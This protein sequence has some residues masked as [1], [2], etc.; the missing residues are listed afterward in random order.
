MRV[1]A[2]VVADRIDYV[3]QSKRTSDS[4]RIT[5][6]C[7]TQTHPLCNSTSMPPSYSLDFL[8][9]PLYC[10]AFRTPLYY[11]F[12]NIIEAFMQRLIIQFLITP[13]MFIQVQ[14]LP[15]PCPVYIPPVLLI[16]TLSDANPREFTLF[17]I[18]NPINIK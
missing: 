6:S 17:Y 11:I 15:R 16:F 7:A 10:V 14:L 9:F 4:Q 13:L 12:F 2:V 8:L 3:G 5:S 1:I 18:S